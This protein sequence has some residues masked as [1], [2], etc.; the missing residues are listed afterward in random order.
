MRLKLKNKML[1]LRRAAFVLLIIL[2][3]SLQNSTGM[4]FAPFDVHAMLLVPLVVCICVH[5]KSVVS[6]LLG[7]F[8]GIMWDMTS[9]TVDGFFTVF[10]ATVGFLCSVLIAFEMRNNIFSALL[11]STV[12]AF[13]C[14]I[15]YWLFFVLIKCYDMAVYVYFRYYFT[16]SLYTALY[17]FVFYYLVRW[18]TQKTADEKK[19]INY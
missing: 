8:A 3:A 13:A 10:L 2:T 6:L 19:R 1:W 9:V 11:L 12:S 14:G 4:V 15:L 18:I 5:E 16:S 17:T 7:A